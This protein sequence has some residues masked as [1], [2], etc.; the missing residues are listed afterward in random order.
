MFNALRQIGKDQEAI[1]YMQEYEQGL[2][3]MNQLYGTK[4]EI[5]FELPK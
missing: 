1:M 3:M 2:Q 4:A 5:T